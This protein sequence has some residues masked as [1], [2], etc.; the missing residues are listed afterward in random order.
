MEP[1]IVNPNVQNETLQIIGLALSALT[2][3]AGTFLTVWAG[4]ISKNHEIKIKGAEARIN[5]LTAYKRALEVYEN[6][7][8]ATSSSL[9]AINSFGASVNQ[10]E[11]LNKMEV[12]INKALEKG[13]EVLHEQ[14]RQN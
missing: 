4:L 8:I 3:L 6:A 11:V 2:T 13:E 10:T 12:T 1:Q 14:Y 9:T 7:L 5:Q